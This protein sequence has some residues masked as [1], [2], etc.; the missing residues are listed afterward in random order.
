M[1]DFKLASAGDDIKIWDCNGYTLVKQYNP[2]PGNIGSLCWS[3]DN[4]F[5]ASTCSGGDRIVLTYMKTAASNAVEVTLGEDTSCTVFSSQSRYVLGGRKDGSLQLWDLKTQKLKKVYK[6]HKSPVSCLSFNWNDTYMASGSESGQIVLHN[7]VTGQASSPLVTPKTQAIRKLQYSNFKKSLLGSVSD[8]GALNLWDVNTRRLLHSFNDMHR[9]PATGLVFSPLNEMLLMS[10][11]LDKRIVCYDVHGKTAVKSVTAD[12]PLTSVDMLHDGVTVA[13]GTTRGM[14]H[15]YDLRQ[16]MTPVRSLNAH[17]S[18]VQCLNFQSNYKPSKDS[19]SKR[20]TSATP[21]TVQPP[22]T[23]ASSIVKAAGAAKSN[24]KMEPETPAQRASLTD[25]TNLTKIREEH[26]Q[27]STEQDMFSPLREGGSGDGSELV[28]N[29]RTFENVPSENRPD[30]VGMAAGVG[31]RQQ[32]SFTAGGVFSPLSANTSNTS[33]RRNPIGAGSLNDSSLLGNRPITTGVSFEDGLHA[34]SSEVH[35]DT[36]AGITD[37]DVESKSYQYMNGTPGVRLPLPQGISEGSTRSPRTP[38]TPR[39]Q[40]AVSDDLYRSDKVTTRPKDL[41]SRETESRMGERHSDSWTVAE[42]SQRQRMT[43]G[44]KVDSRDGVVSRLSSHI[45]SSRGSGDWMDGS[46]W[47]PHQEQHQQQTAYST[48]NSSSNAVVPLSG[49]IG[50]GA[51][52]SG[53]TPTTPQGVPLGIQPFHTEFIRNVV[54]EA[55]EEFRDQMHR[56]H[57]HLQMEMIKQFQIQLHEVRSM[58]Q[59]FSVNEELVAEIHRLREEN[60]RL[61]KNY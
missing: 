40:A 43:S 61:K 54:E 7:A 14:V 25:K 19:G 41:S 48:T 10:V 30:I 53:T 15:I 3:H 44:Q 35:A 51:A 23:A 47:K 28:A 45:T 29:S 18:S 2:H 12:S 55:M 6:D 36:G 13:V 34:K 4:F 49:G 17:K 11:G 27:D 31:S 60:E 32:D 5:L 46:D 20:A 56:E 42:S 33:L 22:K 16:G 21:R 52:A 50:A 37:E 1:G 39:T 9:A 38:R 59:E 24:H 26:L 57:I 8:D 58:L